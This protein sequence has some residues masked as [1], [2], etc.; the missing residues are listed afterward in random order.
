MSNKKARNPSYKELNE[1]IR[2]IGENWTPAMDEA[3]ERDTRE[4]L[5]NYCAEWT[6]E[7]A[8]CAARRAQLKLDLK[9]AAVVRSHRDA[10]KSQLDKLISDKPLKKSFPNRAQQ[11]FAGSQRIADLKLAVEQATSN[12]DAQLAKQ[13][14]QELAMAHEPSYICFK[15]ATSNWMA[16]CDAL[17][18]QCDER[19]YVDAELVRIR[20]ALA[21]LERRELD[22]ATKLRAARAQL[23]ASA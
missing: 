15:L 10:L 6:T 12:S 13:L 19:G 9:K 14:N 2:R 18:R 8:M 23:R 21:E 11:L 17:A 1:M 5:L 20:T 22:L 4:A 7:K 16:S 3:I